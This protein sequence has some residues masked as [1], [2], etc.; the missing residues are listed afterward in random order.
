MNVMGWRFALFLLIGTLALLLLSFMDPTEQTAVDRYT[1]RQ[2]QPSGSK[3]EVLLGLKKLGSAI[4]VGNR[5][6]EWSAR[7]ENNLDLQVAQAVVE[8]ELASTAAPPPR[9]HPAHDEI[10]TAQNDARSAEAELTERFRR[11][12]SIEE[13]LDHLERLQADGPVAASTER[14]FS[15]SGL[16][17]DPQELD[18]CPADQAANYLLEQ[19]EA[20]RSR[21]QVE[22]R[23]Y[24]QVATAFEVEGRLR[25]RLRWLTRAMRSFPQEESVRRAFEGAYLQNGRLQEV[26]LFNGAELGADPDNVRLWKKRAEYCGWMSLVPD[27]I[28]ARER[29]VVHED[30]EE[31]WNRLVELYRSEGAPEKAI[32]HAARLAERTTDPKL[33]DLPVQL[34]LESGRVDEALEHLDL[35]A[36]RSHEPRVWRE[37]AVEYALQDLRLDRAIEE[38]RHLALQYPD[39]GYDEQLVGLYLRCDR[40]QDLVQFYEEKLKQN[41]DDLAVERELMNLHIARGDHDR[42]VEILSARILADPDPRTVFQNLSAYAS[43]G[44]PGVAELALK[45]ARTAEIDESLAID[46]I[47]QWDALLQRPEYR[48]V[49]SAL[50]QRFPSH[51]R[52]IELRLHL[53]DLEDTAEARA[54]AAERWCAEQP[55]SLEAVHAWIDR[56]SWC[57]VT[58]S[59][60]RARE[61]L[62]RMQPMDGTN[63]ALLSDLYTNA[64]REEKNLELWTE[65]ATTDGPASPAAEH[66]V[67]TLFNLGRT[68]E[69]MQWL[70]RRAEDPRATLEDRL[71]VADHLFS[72]Q[73]IDRALLF[74]HEVLREDPRHSHSLLR[75]GQILLWSTDPRGA[76]APLE[77]CLETGG[78][79]EATVRFHLGEAYYETQQSGRAIDQ[80]RLALRWLRKVENPTVEQELMSARIFVRTERFHEAQPIFERLLDQSPDDQNLILDYADALM[81]A[82]DPAAARHWIDAAILAQPESPR[83]LRLSADLLTLEKR[84]DEAV[85]VYRKVSKILHGDAGVEAS[86][87]YVLE[88]DGRTREAVESFT[89]SLA[90]QPDNLDV[91]TTLQRIEDRLAHE[92]LGGVSVEKVA[93]DRTTRVRAAGSGLLEG[94]LTRVSAELA[95]SDYSGR[96]AAVQ[97][98][99]KDVEQSV[100]MLESSVVERFAHENEYGF[101]LKAYAGVPGR[102]PLS[103]WGGLYL[104]KLEPYRSLTFRAAINELWDNPA[105]A[106]GLEG[107]VSSGEAILFHDLTRDFWVSGEARAESLSIDPPDSSTASDLRVSAAVHAG[108]RFLPG[109]LEVHDPLHVDA[110]PLDLVGGDLATDR[111]LLSSLSGWFSLSAIELL[112][113]AE[114]ADLLPIGESFRYLSYSGRADL[115]FP[116]DLG[117]MVSASAGRELRENEWFWAVRSGLAHRPRSTIESSLFFSFGRSTG[118]SDSESF[119]E[120]DLNLTLRF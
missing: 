38:L 35:A 5:L 21:T 31:S 73:R 19:I 43:I 48:E 18:A 62:L 92:M 12:P 108:A 87:G 88:Q 63:R 11:F 74:Y 40:Q 56:A 95:F 32:P 78:Q 6:V 86:L 104:E 13:A 107:R 116:M 47:E 98:G 41:P 37:R 96:A 45:L 28:H 117:V 10:L 16:P 119:L 72:E 66:L 30:D 79:D 84:L 105:A 64:D 59:E 115:Q 54:N 46:S 25:G 33:L 2:V 27:E 89:R 102:L 65:L 34:A 110:V 109:P 1:G 83:V 80:Q 76:V 75:T 52:S 3:I 120:L 71:H 4:S 113:N 7:I 57:G 39:Q 8:A 23:T 118:R 69:A 42:V 61:T 58:D 82:D 50:L 20:S 77:R 60:I 14:F 55:E 68:E 15:S 99:T 36:S 53:V 112:G 67:T 114:L 44:V 24:L 85:V 22:V 103:V 9:L 51:Q 91:R 94:D 97:N 111:I 101:G 90:L 81:S 17:R 49:A 70:E 29:I 100:A 26:L 106:P 93:D